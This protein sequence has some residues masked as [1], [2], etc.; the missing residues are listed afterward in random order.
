MQE[1]Y[2]TPHQENPEEASASIGFITKLLVAKRASVSLRTVDKWIEEKKIP[3]LKIGRS[4]R[5]RWPAVEAAL[6]RFERKE[7]R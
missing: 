7:I 5:F 4:V 2:T 6:L 3:V 1:A